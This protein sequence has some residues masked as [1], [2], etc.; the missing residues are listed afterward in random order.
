MANASQPSPRIVGGAAVTPFAHNW[1]VRGSFD[2]CAPLS[3]LQHS[4]HADACPRRAAQTSAARRS[5]T[6]S[7]RSPPRTARKA[8]RRSTSRSTAT[9]ST[10]GTRASTAAPRRSRRRQRTST[11]STRAPPCRAT[12]LP[13]SGSRRRHSARS[14]G[15]SRRP[16]S[17]TG[18]TAWV[19][20][21]RSWPGGASS[22]RRPLAARP[23]SRRRVRAL[24]LTHTR[25][26]AHPRPP[27][28]PPLLPRGFC[29]A[30]LTVAATA[31][32]SAPFCP[33]LWQVLQQVQQTLLS[34][35]ECTGGSYYGLSGS[36]VSPSMV[37]AA[38]GAPVPVCPCVTRSYHGP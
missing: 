25:S 34:H 14:T 27:P 10:C 31:R 32:T 9:R 4:A 15:R 26:E 11:R 3:A 23:R 5:S 19:A 17:T 21:W 37:C 6:R 2:G 22:R 30:H 20:R 16:R 29:A 13:S 12:T 8:A 7:G 18:G 24:S 33:C 38:G 1:I 28:Q 36:S 35:A